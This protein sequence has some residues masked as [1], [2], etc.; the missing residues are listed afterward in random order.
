MGNC[1]KKESKSAYGHIEEDRPDGD[2]HHSHSEQ[3]HSHSEQEQA[4]QGSHQH[5]D[6]ERE[7]VIRIGEST[8][9]HSK[10][11]QDNLLGVS[12]FPFLAEKQT[13]DFLKISHTMFIMR[14]VPGS[15]KST[16]AKRIHKQYP[17]AVLC[18]AD[19]FFIDTDGIYKYDHSKIG[20]AHEACQ[21]KAKE[22]FENG[23]SV[24]IIDNTNINRWEMSP[25]VKL[26]ELD[27][28]YHLIPVE[29]NTPWK[30]SP[31]ELHNRTTHGVHHDKI[32]QML[33]NL[34]SQH[35]EPLYYGWF[36]N[37]K[38]SDDLYK[39]GTRCLR[40]G[41]EAMGGNANEILN[42]LESHFLK[43]HLM[44]HC[45][46]KYIGMNPK[47]EYHHKEFV[48]KCMYKTF[49]LKV[50]GFSYT[51][52]NIGAKLELDSEQLKL[53]ESEYENEM[54]EHD[55]DSRYHD[56]TA[57]VKKTI[58]VQHGCSAHI[59]LT[60]SH[61]SSA[62]ITGKDM[63]EIWI[64]KKTEKHPENSGSTKEGKFEAWGDDYF[65]FDLKKTVL[66][67]ALFHGYYPRR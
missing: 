27:H 15:G 20:K 5:P 49:K 57:G 65:F 45:T 44:L 33:V 14:G 11:I 6:Q 47:H 31:D 21:Q 29:P 16:L 25:Y 38:D 48:R 4:N 46:A 53:F 13:I 8:Q 2:G 58:D 26:A 23:V 54:N 17:D 18:S 24:I 35:F 56:T 10:V 50:T 64:R 36:L 43:P 19:D 40:E 61:D 37:H 34:E 28:F 63:L 32:K 66:Y 59:T 12:E 62:R 60:F 39:L 3:H 41:V 42:S 22:S 51:M 67:T 30:D 9:V 52:T 55:E 7:V 1:L